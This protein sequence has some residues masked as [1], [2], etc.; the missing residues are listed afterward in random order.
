MRRVIEIMKESYILLRK[1]KDFT[2]KLNRVLS[3]K[4]IKKLYNSLKKIEAK[5]LI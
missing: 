5:I 4:H 2:T 1:I 3:N